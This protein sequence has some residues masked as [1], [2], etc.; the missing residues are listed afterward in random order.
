MMCDPS[1]CRI[2]TYQSTIRKSAMK[3]FVAVLALISTHLCRAQDLEEHS[4]AGAQACV[5][6]DSAAVG[7]G[8][9][10]GL[11]PLHEEGSFNGSADAGSQQD[12]TSHLNMARAVRSDGPALANAQSVLFRTDFVGQSSFG[13]DLM[14]ADTLPRFVRPKLLPDNMSFLEGWIWG[15]NGL[16]RGVGIASPLTPEVR[17]H[18]LAIRRTM[19]TMHQIGGFLTLGSMIATVYFGQKSLNDPNTGQRDDPYR[20]THQALVTSTI[21][22]YATTGL[23]AVLSPPPLIRRDETST[24]TI[25]KTL[26]WIHFAGMVL[27]PIIGNTILKRGPSGRYADLNR[28]RFHQISAYATTTVFAASM[29]VM[30]F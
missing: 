13:F 30:L 25:H 5:D 19:L 21:A 1:V 16:L 2:A 22:L 9:H 6:L 15:E 10:D 29:I 3:I 7:P 14:N 20:S 11:Q 26:A 24:T 23:L 4:G 8:S 27:T 12:L 18:E 17:K 28:A